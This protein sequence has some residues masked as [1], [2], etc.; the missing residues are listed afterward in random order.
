VE[1]QLGV[2][3]R[4]RRAQRGED[5]PVDGHPAVRRDGLLHRQPRDLVPEPQATAASGAVRDAVGGQQSA[6]QQFV[7]GV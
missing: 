4:A 6:G 7:H 2:V 5:P 1:G 3:L